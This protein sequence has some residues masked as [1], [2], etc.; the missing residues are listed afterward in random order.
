MLLKA[1]INNME[2][3]SFKEFGFYSEHIFKLEQL[4]YERFGNNL[5]INK[6]QKTIK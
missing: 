5:E 4:Y 1:N 6:W 3:R 2:F